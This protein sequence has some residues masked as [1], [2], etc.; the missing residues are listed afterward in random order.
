M[1]QCVVSFECN[2]ACHKKTYA[3]VAGLWLYTC[4]ARPS[5]AQI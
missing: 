2:G 3:D 5:P 1:D 4:C